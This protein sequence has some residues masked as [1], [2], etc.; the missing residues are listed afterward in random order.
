[1]VFIFGGCALA[2]RFLNARDAAGSI[3]DGGG[4]DRLTRMWLLLAIALLPDS[5]APADRI[6]ARCA[7]PIAAAVDAF[8]Y[9]IRALA[10]PSR[11]RRSSPEFAAR[12]DLRN[13]VLKAKETPTACEVEFVFVPPGKSRAPSPT[14]R[15]LDGKRYLVRKLDSAIEHSY[16][17]PAICAKA[18]APAL[19]RFERYGLEDGPEAL[20][21]PPEPEAK[22]IDLGRFRLSVSDAPDTCRVT[23]S[24]IIP[25]GAVSLDSWMKYDVRKSDLAVVA[26]GRFLR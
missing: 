20:S 17:L 15:D 18:I 3:N 9:E 10:W 23:F 2:A 6:T 26:Q 14:P 22:G 11:D 7:R 21:P 25:K 4:T 8:Q 12:T 1:L 19:W 16:S 24:Q 13:Y 5:E